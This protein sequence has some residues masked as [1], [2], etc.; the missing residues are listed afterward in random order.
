MEKIKCYN[1]DSMKPYEF[2]VD[3]VFY[4]FKNGRFELKAKTN[5]E[6]GDSMEEVKSQQQSDMVNHPN[7]YLN[8]NGVECQDVIDYVLKNVDVTKTAAY[9]LGCSIK[10]L[11]RYKR[12]GKPIQDLSKARFCFDRAIDYLKK[13]VEGEN[14]ED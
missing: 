1:C 10:Y 9:W 14:N 4:A 5:N 2:T 8:E 11:F 3:N 7:H 13:D 12:K 6:Q